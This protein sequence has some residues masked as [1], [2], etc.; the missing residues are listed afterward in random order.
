MFELLSIPA[1]I[2]AIE[3]FKMAGLPS[4]LAAIGA[5][6]IGVTFGF[7]MGDAVTGLLLGLASSGTYSAAKNLL[8]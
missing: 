2:A 4:K 1:I 3:A 5:I 7:I 8:Q 6:G